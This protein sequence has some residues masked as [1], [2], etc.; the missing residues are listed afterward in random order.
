[1]PKMPCLQHLVEGNLFTFTTDHCMD[2]G[3]V[4]TISKPWS[5][6]IF[7]NLMDTKLWYLL[8]T[9]IIPFM[10]LNLQL[11]L[12]FLA[13]ASPGCRNTFASGV[14][15]PPGYIEACNKNTPPFA[16]GG[17]SIL[18]RWESE[19]E[20]VRVIQAGFFAS[21][22]HIFRISLR[23]PPRHQVAEAVRIVDCRVVLM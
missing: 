10:A 3:G 4:S 13:S 18:Q 23:F 14:A 9:E 1:M 5:K 7:P 8:S 22:A 16:T 2:I 12:G 20:S 19:L 21:V 17:Q 15:R 11:W 6:H